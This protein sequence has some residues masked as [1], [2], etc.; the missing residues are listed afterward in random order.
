MGT[1][2]YSLYALAHVALA[3]MAVQ[4]LRRRATWTGI[5]V[6]LLAVTLAFDNG[7]LVLGNT[8]GEGVLLRTLSW[9]RFIIHAFATPV[10]IAVVVDQGRRL[11]V[12]RLQGSGAMPG[13]WLLTLAMVALGVVE[14]LHLELEAEVGMG[15]LRY[16]S[17]D[18][19]IPIPAIVAVIAMIVVGR[20]V[21]KHTGWGLLFTLGIVSFIGS[22][23]P[24]IDGMLVFGNLV[25]IAFVA[26]LLLAEQRTIDAPTPAPAPA[27]ADDDAVAAA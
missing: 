15:L 6:L 27:P 12:P 1:A 16:G 2:I 14:L 11:G 3:V 9:P 7:M 5:V 26:A 25:E 4:V 24:P 10:A 18:P 22:A 20:M 8:I 21:E 13:A 17:V 23:V 19:S